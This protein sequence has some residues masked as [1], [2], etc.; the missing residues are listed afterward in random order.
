MVVG[1][2]LEQDLGQAVEQAS[3]F[4]VAEPFARRTTWRRMRC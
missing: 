4:P 3:V 1:V 2:A